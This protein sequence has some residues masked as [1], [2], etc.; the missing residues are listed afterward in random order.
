MANALFA[1]FEIKKMFR[2]PHY[3]HLLLQTSN[4]FTDT[5]SRGV[6]IIFPTRF[7]DL[8]SMLLGFILIVF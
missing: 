7:R 5:F 4:A 8:S 3:I 6:V 1:A 2:G